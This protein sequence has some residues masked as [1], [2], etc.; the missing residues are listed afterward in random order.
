M[1]RFTIKCE[2]FN[3]PAEVQLDV[4]KIPGEP[5]PTYMVS[6][7][8]MFRGYITKE[9]S[10]RYKQLMNAVF[11]DVDMTII[12]NELAKMNGNK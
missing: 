5:G 4:K 1:E 7:E 3:K 10:G 12:N 11:T 8:G 9:R 2:I 6:V